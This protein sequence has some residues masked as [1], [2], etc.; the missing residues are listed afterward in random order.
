MISPRDLIPECLW[1]S[2][3]WAIL[4]FFFFFNFFKVKTQHL[5]TF[6]HV[7]RSV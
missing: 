3:H 2:D 6:C 5:L 7:S 1:C 4:D